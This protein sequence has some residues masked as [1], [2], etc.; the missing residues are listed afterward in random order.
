M[1]GKLIFGVLL[2]ASYILYSCG[3]GSGSSDTV[4]NNTNGNNNS[5]A[6]NPVSNIII[7]SDTISSVYG[8][9]SMKFK[10][11]VVYKNTT[12]NSV[13]IQSANNKGNITIIVPHKGTSSI[14]LNISDPDD[15]KVYVTGDVNGSPLASNSFFGINSNGTV[16]NISG[17]DY[18][19]NKDFNNYP[20]IEVG[21]TNGSGTL[22]WKFQDLSGNSEGQSFTISNFALYNLFTQGSQNVLDLGDYFNTY[23]LQFNKLPVLSVVP[24]NNCPVNM[25]D[26]NN[27]GVY[28]RFEIPPN[29]D[30]ISLSF[31]N[32]DGVSYNAEYSLDNG[33]TYNPINFGTAFDWTSLG[34][35]Q[36]V[37]SNKNV[38]VREYIDSAQTILDSKTYTLTLY[39]DKEFP[40]N[41]TGS[42]T[43]NSTGST[44]AVNDGDIITFGDPGTNSNAGVI[45]VSGSSADYGDCR[46]YIVKDRDI[47]NP[48]F[49]EIQPCNSINASYTVPASDKGTGT[50]TLELG[51]DKIYKISNNTNKNV[52]IDYFAIGYKVN[53]SPTNQ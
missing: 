38:G 32:D 13:S 22:D 48:V 24:S 11:G 5:S 1:K 51:V 44:F 41:L 29:Y 21:I 49:D 17:Y 35:A 39:K 30:C 18:Q 23:T 27:D 16:K 14:T 12:D 9:A 25:V 20:A 37:V 31:S 36:G 26:T 15:N 33:N 10:D 46:I 6:P 7:S 40:G 50:H 2:S 45:S 3:G 53:Q 34:L 28:D 4:A 43:D 19:S 42:A 8:T 52:N 47:N